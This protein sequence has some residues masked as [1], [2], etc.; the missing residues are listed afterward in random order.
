MVL[1][2]IIQSCLGQWQWSVTTGR[3]P[4]IAKGAI[5]AHRRP[6]W[7]SDGPAV[8]DEGRACGT[9]LLR[10][11]MTA[12]GTRKTGN[13]R[14]HEHMDCWKTKEPLTLTSYKKCHQLLFHL[15]IMKSV[16]IE[17]TSPWQPDLKQDK[18]YLRNL[19]PLLYVWRHSTSYSTRDETVSKL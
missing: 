13:T 14:P 3:V 17:W 12:F 8:R 15:P 16:K 1:G 11:T 5:S 19:Q 10:P 4:V 2:K 7:F 9:R 18:F 6:F